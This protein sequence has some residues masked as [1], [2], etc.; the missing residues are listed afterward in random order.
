MKDGICSKL[1]KQSWVTSKSIKRQS[2][3]ELQ[4]WIG[5]AFC[6]NIHPYLPTVTRK[7][8]TGKTDDSGTFVKLLTKWSTNRPWQQHYKTPYNN[9]HVA[10]FVIMKRAPPPWVDNP[11]RSKAHCTKKHVTAKK[12]QHFDETV[13]FCGTLETLWPK[14]N[15]SG[16]SSI[17]HTSNHK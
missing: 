3:T 7:W 11:K 9:E 16:S 10:H 14:I 12:G 1:R 2:L 13:S 6:R 4:K 15:P 5:N 8:H 17:Y